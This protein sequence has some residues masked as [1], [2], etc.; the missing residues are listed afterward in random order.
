MKVML[1]LVNYTSDDE[2]NDNESD[3]NAQEIT[4]LQQAQSKEPSTTSASASKTTPKPPPGQSVFN[5]KVFETLK[6]DKGG[7]V[8]RFVI[9]LSSKEKDLNDEEDEDSE[10]EREQLRKKRKLME[11]RAKSEP[12]GLTSLLPPP[13]VSPTVNNA[14]ANGAGEKASTAQTTLAFKPYIF[15]KKEQEKREIERKNQLEKEK[16]K[17]TETRE[18]EEEE[19]EVN[20]A[21][22]SNNFFFPMNLKPSSFKASESVISK[23]SKDLAPNVPERE[24]QSHPQVSNYH[25]QAPS[26]DQYGEHDEQQY[27]AQYGQYED[28]DEEDEQEFL[29]DPEFQKFMSKK[30][31][32]RKEEH[33]QIIEVNSD[34][35]LDRK[36]GERYNPLKEAQFQSSFKGSVKPVVGRQKKKHQITWLASHAASMEKELLDRSASSR[37]TKQQTQSRYGF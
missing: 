2:D 16:G 23:K 24:E 15:Q 31:K 4:N 13:K 29:N 3:E 12:A 28:Q 20:Q 36:P 14:R 8:K 27:Y 35:L 9:D 22:P 30:E 10:E 32:V 17:A 34:K 33:T 21:L 26:T 18:E 19:E 5:P 6:S 11:S 37:I 25:S 7:N 1:G